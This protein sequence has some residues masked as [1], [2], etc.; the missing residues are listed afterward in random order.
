MTTKNV[1]RNKPQFDTNPTLSKNLTPNVPTFNSN[2]M[3]N[4]G[5]VKL[6]NC[7]NEC[8]CNHEKAHKK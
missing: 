1:Y 5:F 4:Q 2:A 6:D 8:C 7:S 3:G